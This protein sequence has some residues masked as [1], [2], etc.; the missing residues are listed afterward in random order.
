MASTL[1][2][3]VDRI[4]EILPHP[5]PETVALELA[6]VKNWWCCIK[7]G[8]FS[9]GDAC[10]YVP[11]GTV[12]PVEVTDKWGITNYT[13]SM[14]R[15]GDGTQPTSRRIRATRLRGTPS[16]GVILPVENPEWP[17]GHSVVEYYGLSKYEPVQ[18]ND[19]EAM[20]P[21]EEFHKYT[22]V[23]SYGN[24]PNI[25]KEGEEVVVD[26]K[27]H[28]KNL[29]AGLVH[30]GTDFVLMVGSHNQRMR[31]ISSKGVRSTFWTIM[32][33]P[34]Q[35][36]LRHVSE[37]HKAYER[38]ANVVV[39]A[40]LFGR[41]IQDMEYGR[42]DVGY[43]AYDISVN[44]EYLSYIEKNR[45]FVYFGIPVA[46]ALYRGPFSDKKMQELV[47]GPTTMCD[48][49]EAGRFCGREGIVIRPIVER[50]EPG[51]GRAI[52]KLVSVDYENRKG[53]KTEYH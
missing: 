31:E 52:L 32:D 41:K 13:S 34:M 21:V 43:R 19:G 12:V 5:D 23:E 18:I 4:A 7:K 30:D 44:G 10:V 9:V 20:P 22:D 39:F 40:E 2:V 3:E 17:V 14:P 53:D 8:S 48:P 1:I 35:N 46:P 25:F 36:L 37:Q 42:G 11:P 27:I 26:E 50:I 38:N 29:R 28:G 49:K 15:L 45:L 6:R 51:F 33:E 47:D 24:F 16:R